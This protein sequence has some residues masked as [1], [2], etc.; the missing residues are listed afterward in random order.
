MRPPRHDTLLSLPAEH[1]R[2]ALARDEALLAEVAAAGG[3]ALERWWVASTPA[4]VVGLG[5]RRRL[6]DIVDVGYCQTVG[7]DVLDRQAGGGVVL[8]DGH[9]VCGAMCVPL[10]DPRV[11]D[12]ITESYRW[13][14]EHLVARLR[15]LGVSDARRVEVDE[16]RSN[17][18]ALRSADDPVAR[19]LLMTCY[20][21]LSSHE[22]VVG[23]S[24]KLVGLAQIRRRHAALFQFGI[25]LRDQSPLVDFLVI[26]DP[27]TRAQLRAEL[28]QRTV[29]LESLSLAGRSVSAMAA[30]VAGATPCGP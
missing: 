6:A 22:I 7:M 15:A 19:L 27:S 10:P 3:Q 12:D 4:I 25:L 24:R 8:L 18:R 21:A 16:A 23:Q 2:E 28:V 13:L 29:G 26:P 1:P 17:L 30:A 20:S 9:M 5:L 11:G 14:G